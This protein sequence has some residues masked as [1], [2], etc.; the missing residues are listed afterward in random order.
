[1]GGNK[2]NILD[3]L[4]FLLTYGGRNEVMDFSKSSYYDPNECED[5]ILNSFHE[6]I[7]DSVDWD[8]Y[9]EVTKDGY[10]NKR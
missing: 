3:K 2:T 8:L 7:Q 10:F 6:Y 5:N 1:M 4:Y 9:K